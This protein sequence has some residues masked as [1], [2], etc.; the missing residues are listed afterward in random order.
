MAFT[1][2]DICNMALGAIGQDEVTSLAGTTKTVKLLN[3]FYPL[4][5]DEVLASHPWNCAR[6]RAS[7]TANVTAP[8]W[9]YAV[10]YDLPADCIRVLKVETSCDFAT[11]PWKVEG[12][13]I[14]TDLASPIDIQY[15][16]RIDESLFSP[17]LTAALFT[18]LAV[19]LAEPIAQSATL[20]EQLRQKYEAAL[21]RA[22]SMNAQ[23][24]T[25]DRP[26]A[27]A[28]VDAMRSA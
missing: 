27:D 28:F 9:E 6:A 10:A 3:R 26:R 22:R 19:E 21:R 1:Q 4:C 15:I 7:L 5:R 12:A 2:L 14:V 13:Q 20:A 18:R 8:V 11:R 23:E 24:G 16:A 25:P 17:L